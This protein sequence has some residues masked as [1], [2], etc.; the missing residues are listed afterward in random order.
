[1]GTPGVPLDITRDSIVTALKHTKGQPTKACKLLNCSHPALYKRINADPEI[2][3]LIA[4]LRNEADD[5]F[6]D[7]A[8]DGI[9]HLMTLQETNVDKFTAAT[10]YILNNRGRKRGWVPPNVAASLEGQDTKAAALTQF[11]QQAQDYA[12][13]Q[14]SK[15]ASRRVSQASGVLPLEEKDKSL[16]TDQSQT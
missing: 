3:E 10:F 11:L 13:W 15:N 7:M 8:E 1:M 16:L 12:E 9:E 2:Q 6:L 5:K 14:A 4:Q